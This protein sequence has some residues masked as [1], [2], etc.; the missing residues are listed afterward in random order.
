MN[1]PE[2]NWLNMALSLALYA[3]VAMTFA[4]AAGVIAGL[5]TITN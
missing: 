1:S 2:I 5:L 3:L 4:A